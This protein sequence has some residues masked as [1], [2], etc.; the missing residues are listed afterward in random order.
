MA[1]STGYSLQST[2]YTHK[3]TGNFGRA[4]RE[5]DD[6]LRNTGTEVS[7]SAGERDGRITGGAI[8]ESNQGDSSIFR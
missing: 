6:V 8:S 3:L 7:Q 4:I 2:V 5:D 1:V